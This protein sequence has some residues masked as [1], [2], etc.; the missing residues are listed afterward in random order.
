MAKFRIIVRETY[1]MAHEAETPADAGR[2][3]LKCI[4]DHRD[5][6]LV[7]QEVRLLPDEEDFEWE[8]YPQSNEMH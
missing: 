8:D 6:H 4:N 2:L 3:A 7:M 1:M 5:N